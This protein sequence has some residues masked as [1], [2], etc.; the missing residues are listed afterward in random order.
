MKEETFETCGIVELE[1]WKKSQANKEIKFA[2]YTAISDQE[3]VELLSPFISGFMTAPVVLYKN[4]ALCARTQRID[5]LVEFK[6]YLQE[7]TSSIFLYQLLWIPSFPYYKEL[8]NDIGEL[9]VIID[10]P[11]VRN[12]FWTIRY[13]EEK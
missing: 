4:K 13:A 1:E 12:G 9:V 6:K 8:D 11:Y 2:E 10:G 5:D 7:T 3:G